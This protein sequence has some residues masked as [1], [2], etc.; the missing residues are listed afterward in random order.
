MSSDGPAYPKPQAQTVLRFSPAEIEE[1]QS[2]ARRWLD[3]PEE[4]GGWA[5][6]WSLVWIQV[7][8][9][10]LS[11]EGVTPRDVTTMLREHSGLVDK[12]TKALALK[13]KPG[14]RAQ[15]KGPIDPLRGVRHN[16]K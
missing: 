3:N 11:V 15:D 9:R 7:A 5:Q 2:Q 13:K 12:I 8:N 1:M 10:V 16:A 6:E 14:E 4:F